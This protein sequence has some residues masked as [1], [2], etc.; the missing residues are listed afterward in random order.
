MQ[1]ASH[2]ALINQLDPHFESSIINALVQLAKRICKQKTINFAVLFFEQLNTLTT[3]FKSEYDQV[4]LTNAQSEH[5]QA[6]PDRYHRMLSRLWDE[7]VLLDCLE[8]VVDSCSE[9]L[10]VVLL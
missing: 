5:M 7:D 10:G 4:T 8:L 6:L 1:S 2:Q 3:H 9:R